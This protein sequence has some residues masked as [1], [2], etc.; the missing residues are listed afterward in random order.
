VRSGVQRALVIGNENNLET[1]ETNLE[2]YGENITFETTL[3]DVICQGDYAKVMINGDRVLSQQKTGVSQGS[4]QQ[5]EFIIEFTTPAN[6]KNHRV[7]QYGIADLVDGKNNSLA[8]KNAIR[9]PY[10]TSVV[11]ETELI[12][13]SS[14]S[15]RDVFVD[16]AIIKSEFILSI[17]SQPIVLSSSVVSSNISAG[18]PTFTIE[19]FPVIKNPYSIGNKGGGG[20]AFN[21]NHNRYANDMNWTLKV[22]YQTTPIPSTPN[23]PVNNPTSLTDCILWLDAANEQSVTRSGIAVSGWADISGE[24]NSVLQPT[25]VFKPTYRTDFWHRPSLFF[26]GTSANL[27]STDTDLL[28]LAVQNNTFVA[29]F[30]STATSSETNGQVIVGH[31]QPTNDCRV[32]LRVNASGNGGD[33]L[34]SV[35]FSSQSSTTNQNSCSIASA[36]ITD[37]SIAVGRRDGTATKIRFKCSSNEICN[38]GSINKWWF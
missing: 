28:A 21:V 36:S 33:G 17:S 14:S 9:F 34:D 2:R 16:K 4:N 8:N 19:A 11:V 29:C 1:F 38:W 37:V 32:G 27:F 7:G 22:N 30:H 35:C 25:S 15:T 5:G 20:I 12:G 10:K 18:L 6:T 3:R 23:L 26:D 13:F 24:T 31:S